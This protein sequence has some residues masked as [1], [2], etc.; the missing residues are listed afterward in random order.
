MINQK[1]LTAGVLNI[2]LLFVVLVSRGSGAGVNELGAFRPPA[3]PLVTVDPYMSVD[4]PVAR[5]G[6]YNSCWWACV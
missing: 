2:F 1:N 3:V 6:W 5:N 4:R